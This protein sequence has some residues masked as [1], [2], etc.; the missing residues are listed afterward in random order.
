MFW[1]FVMSLL[2]SNAASQCTFDDRV[3]DSSV[4]RNAL[5]PNWVKFGRYNGITIVPFFFTRETD[6]RTRR[7]MINIFLQIQKEMGYG[8]PIR[9]EQTYD[10]NDRRANIH[11]RQESRQCSYNQAEGYVHRTTEKSLDLVM[12]VSPCPSNLNVWRQVALHEMFHVFGFGHTQ[13]RSDRDKYI[14]V[15]EENIEKNSTSQYEK[16]EH[17]EIPGNFPYECDSLMH[18]TDTTYSIDPDRKKTMISI[19]EKLC[20][21]EALSR[22][23]D[24]ATKNDWNMLR[25]SLGCLSQF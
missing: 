8:C 1:L 3:L 24:H 13:R 10:E 14:K 25:Y 18:Y 22:G 2:V 19:N 16:C 12:A 4:S 17:C 11:V 23:N 5:E 9:F 7:E 21:S 15:I 20:P 6:R